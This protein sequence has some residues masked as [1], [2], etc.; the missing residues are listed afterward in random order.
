MDLLLL[1]AIAREPLHGYGV[2]EAIRDASAGELDLAEG[3]VYP[4]LYRLEGAGLLSSKWTTVGGR[5]RRVYR[6]TRLGRRRLERER[7]DW[8]AF[9]GAVKAVT[10]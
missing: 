6:L 4:A 2:V 3:T 5:R 10:A 1:A 9:A 8:N 7:K